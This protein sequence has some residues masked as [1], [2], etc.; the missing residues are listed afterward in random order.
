MTDWSGVP[1]HRVVAVEATLSGHRLQIGSGYLVSASTVLTAAHCT[2]DI[3]APDRPVSAL[4]VIAPGGFSAAIAPSDVVRDPVL[5]I[6][7]L[8]VPSPPWAATGDWTDPRWARIDRS[9]SGVVPNCEAVGY[10]MWQQDVSDDNNRSPAE[11]RGAV[12]RLE[13]VTSRNRFLVLRDP[14]LTDVAPP[15]SARSIGDPDSVWG[16]ISG[17]LVFGR[18]SAIGVVVEHHPRQGPG[19][20]RVLPLDRVAAAD[21]PAAA[22]VAAQLGLPPIDRFPWAFPDDF[23]ALL[24]A[25]EDAADEAVP[26]LRGRSRELATLAGLGGPGPSRRRWVRAASFAGKTALLATFAAHPPPRTTVV[27]CLLNRRKGRNSARYLL[28]SLTMQLA[29]VAWREGYVPPSDEWSRFDDFRRLLTAAAAACAGRGDQLLMIIDGLDEYDRDAV[30]ELGEWLPAD[31]PDGM[32]LLVSSRPDPPGLPADH[33]LHDAVFDLAGHDGAEGGKE[34]ARAELRSAERTDRITRLVL[35]YLAVVGGGLTTSDLAELLGAPGSRVDAELIERVFDTALGRTVARGPDDQGDHP[36]VFDHDYYAAAAD[37]L[38]GGPP[39]AHARRALDDWADRYRSDGWPSSTPRFLLSGYVPYLRSRVVEAANP[40]DRH[41][42]VDRLCA[43]V[44]SPGRWTAMLLR[45]RTPVSPEAEIVESQK[46]VQSALDDGVLQ[47]SEA[48][49]VWARL[50]LA[51][52]GGNRGI[53]THVAGPVAG[54]WALDGDAEAAAD[55]ATAI[56]EPD[57]R[58]EAL[59]EVAVAVGVGGSRAQLGIAL[60]RV[61]TTARTAGAFGDSVRARIALR[62]ARVGR[63]PEAEMVGRSIGHTADQVTCLAEIGLVAARSGQADPARALTRSVAAAAERT[64]FFEP[65]RP[66]GRAAEILA[67]LGDHDDAERL[68]DRAQA[69][70]STGWGKHEFKY[71]QWAKIVVGTA[72]WR[73]T[74]LRAAGLD[75]ADDP[76]LR[77]WFD[78]GLSWRLTLLGPFVHAVNVAGVLA[79]RGFV[80]AARTLA[81]A[82]VD[83]QRTRTDQHEGAD[84]CGAGAPDIATVLLDAG[85]V[86]PVLAFVDIPI[87]PFRSV[88]GSDWSQW[89]RDRIG[90]ALVRALARAGR[91]EDIAA[92]LRQIESDSVRLRAE[93]DTAYE[94]VLYD[95]TRAPGAVRRARQVA[96][97]LLVQ[98]VDRDVDQRRSALLRRIDD[99]LDPT[100]G[101]ESGPRSVSDLLAITH[102]RADHLAEADRARAREPDVESEVAEY[103]DA[104]GGLARAVQ[105]LAE[106]DRFAAAPWAADIE[107]RAWSILSGVGNWEL[108]LPDECAAAGAA[109]AALVELGEKRLAQSLAAALLARLGEVAGPTS[110]AMMMAECLGSTACA[111]AAADALTAKAVDDVRALAWSTRGSPTWERA[112]TETAARIAPAAGGTPEM[113][114]LAVDLL[115]ANQV[116]KVHQAYGWYRP[117]LAVLADLVRHRHDDLAARVADVLLRAGSDPDM[118]WLQEAEVLGGLLRVGETTTKDE[119]LRRLLLSPAFDDYAEN[120]PIELLRMIQTRLG[121]PP[122]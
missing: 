116:W 66:L 81:S 110:D 13:D 120:V 90:A 5:D 103:L 46:A 54:V 100:A 43:V 23:G 19:A 2:I 94:A 102:R 38:V 15:R 80:D 77:L 95:H 70:T 50:A 60:E 67:R 14:E 7:T 56:L 8:R 79:E 48:E 74:A 85:L 117:A 82:A 53:V 35:Q 29:A 114:R 122:S 37:E 31:L 104:A 4:R 119:A 106:V 58:T 1:H 9:A 64:G 92:R 59:G 75:V 55:F 96:D 44:A 108:R 91:P 18:G 111:H 65:Y 84:F 16:G 57:G 69:L 107:R 40:D 36:W 21:S 76:E 24:R 112:T 33:P 83:E 98:A 97:G 30:V 115:L 28:D 11:V 105:D 87:S 6:A 73:C 61:L 78:G 51:R 62:L 101:V 86:E 99:R 32:S 72:R 41:A 88:F 26:D 34:L 10:P 22:G 113:A 3:Q 52:R 93:A 39:A 47:R 49:V 45:H 17:A 109:V 27:S 12:R 89:T 71:R 42:V 25:A 121:R 20:V 63:F 118:L 68:L